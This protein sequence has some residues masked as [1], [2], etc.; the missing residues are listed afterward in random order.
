MR[1]SLPWASPPVRIREAASCPPPPPYGTNVGDT[2]G[3]AVLEDCDG[4]TYTIHD[5]CGLKASW[6]FNYAGW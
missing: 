2:T 6:I 5:L 4:N 1:A 3:D